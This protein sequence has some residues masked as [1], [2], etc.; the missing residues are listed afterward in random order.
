MSTEVNLVRNKLI[1]R[2][3][4]EPMVIFRNLSL[5]D[6]ALIGR[7]WPVVMVTYGS[8]GPV[9][10]DDWG[11]EEH[12]EL[13]GYGRG[14]IYDSIPRYSKMTGKVKEGAIKGRFLDMG[15][16]FQINLEIKPFSITFH[17][18]HI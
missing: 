16:S 11:K 6:G 3:L 13:I 9:N 10:T 2:K 5:V 4:K 8:G 12:H 17:L 14:S 7:G 1:R 18:C 15:F